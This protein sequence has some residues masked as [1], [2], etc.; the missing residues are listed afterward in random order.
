M[1]RATRPRRSFALKWRILTLFA[2]ASM[3]FPASAY[4]QAPEQLTVTDISTADRAPELI[5]AAV[6]RAEK[7]GITLDPASLSVW[8]IAGDEN[9]TIV[10]PRS[11][12]TPDVTRDPQTNR[13]TFGAHSFPVPAED[14]HRPTVAFTT[15]S[16][17][18][19][20]SNCWIGN[21]SASWWMDTC[22]KLYRVSDGDP[23]FDYFALDLSATGGV[24]STLL[25]LSDMWIHSQRSGGST[26]TMWDRSPD[27]SSSMSCTNYTIGISAGVSISVPVRQCEQWIPTFYTSAG[28]FKNL[29]RE[30][31]FSIINY[32]L[33][34]EVEFL[35]GSKVPPSGWPSYYFN[36]NS[37]SEPASSLT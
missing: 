6:A 27:S 13:Q 22:Y 23:N 15:T 31:A 37:G 18:I 7:Y 10:G 29:W 21:H 36:W 19:V 25:E 5:E 4:A 2:S 3:V 33:T 26:Q 17:T 8:M 16:S 11:G 1:I 35:Y 24:T 34:R 28:E 30:G 9:N 14:A 32:P 12:G 20:E